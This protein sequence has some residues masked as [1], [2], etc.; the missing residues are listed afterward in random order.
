MPS[1]LP[2][3]SITPPTPTRSVSPYPTP[4]T[5]ANLLA[6]PL[7]GGPFERPRSPSAESNQSCETFTSV[8]ESGASTLSQTSSSHPAI[9]SDGRHL[10]P[11]TVPSGGH[12]R[13]SSVSS[14]TS[15]TSAS[16][17]PSRS[18]SPANLDV[19]GKKK[20]TAYDGGKVGVLGGG[21]KLG[22]GGGGG[23]APASPRRRGG[24][25]SRSRSSN[26]SQQAPFGQPL[27]ALPSGYQQ[28]FNSQGV[29]GV[30]Y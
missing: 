19:G 3:R 22:G 17:I 25:H 6:L 8:S 9:H 20:P 14:A 7:P 21:V 18:T 4:L 16:S 15:S 29:F 27:F 2:S 12:K 30:G 28:P 13:I 24:Q 10:L 26:R 5:S 1:H 11:S 23:G